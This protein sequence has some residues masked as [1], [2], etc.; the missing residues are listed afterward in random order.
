M[1]SLLSGFVAGTFDAVVLVMSLSFLV[2]FIVVVVIIVILCCCHRYHLLLLI[3][4]LTL[5]S[6]SSGFVAGTFGAVSPLNPSARSR[7]D[8]GNNAS[9]A[10]FRTN[11]AIGPNLELSLFVRTRASDGL[12]AVL[13]DVTRTRSLSVA[14]GSG[15]LVVDVNVDGSR[16]SIPL[17]HKINDGLW[18]FVTLNRSEISVDNKTFQGVLIPSTINLQHTY[19]GGLDDYSAFPQNTLPSE[20]PFRGCVQDMRLDNK[21]FEFYPLGSPLDSY[22]LVASAHLGQGCPGQDVCGASP[23]GRGGVCRDQWD[24]YRCD[25]HPRFGGPDCSLYG[26]ALVNS[27][28]ESSTCVDVGEHYECE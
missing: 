3:P 12:I 4:L 16:S 22:E 21:L 6:L 17:N 1:L 19:I 11:V 9:Y 2:F 18:H 20:T 15:G 27:C 14:L 5:L 8:V 10:K 24:E 13:T 25:C 28:P 23:C 7:R 26:C